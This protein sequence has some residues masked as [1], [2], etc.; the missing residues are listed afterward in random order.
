[1]APNDELAAIQAAL[2]LQPQSSRGEV[3]TE[4]ELAA[5]LGTAAAANVADFATAAQGTAA[6]AA[7]A[8]AAAP[9]LI[10][11]TI[12][13]ALVAGTNVTITPNDGADTIT[14]AAS[15]GGGGPVFSVMDFGAKG[16]GTDDAA[17]IQAA[18][19]ALPNGG[20]VFF[21]RGSYRVNSTLTIAADGVTL[22]GDPLGS[23]LAYYGAAGTACIT[24]DPAAV[25]R[26]GGIE[27]LFVSCITAGATALK[28]DNAYRWIMRRC[29]F[30]SQNGTT[31]IGI[32]IVG[33]LTKSCNLSE[34]H[35]CS[36]W[37]S[38]AALQMNDNVNGIRFIGGVLEG[39]GYAVNMPGTNSN[40][41]SNM[42]IGTAIQSEG[43]NTAGVII[44]MG[45]PSGTPQ[46]A[47]NSFIGCRIETAAATTIQNNAQAWY[48]QI[49]GGSVAVT[50][51]IVDSVT[52]AGAQLMTFYAANVDYM[53]PKNVR[54]KAMVV[55]NHGGTAAV[56]LG[57]GGLLASG[58]NASQ[59]LYLRS[60]GSSSV[61]V[62]E[63]ANDPTGGLTVFSGGATSVPRAVLGAGRGATLYPPAGG[64]ALWVI[65]NGGP[66]N[67]IV[68]ID[69]NG[70][71]KWGDV[72]TNVVDVSVGRSAAGVLAI[73]GP[74]VFQTTAPAA[75]AGAALPATPAGYLKVNINGTDRFM[76]YY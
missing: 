19:N 38:L 31:G 59:N 63:F 35:S 5:A 43:T 16:D 72:T 71:I 6:D 37:G 64:E 73:G 50:T 18:I 1:M 62:N 48:N 30:E 8:A 25:R 36:A 45:Q 9:E 10:R 34:F 42:F 22:K 65:K 21:P 29:R 75:G 66:A 49:I 28:L 15:G 20:T 33:S 52:T 47:Y 60:K 55:T 26:N 44:T 39:P 32:D 41:G 51:T 53:L 27:E 61:T 57:N 17:A 67:P 23:T 54:T 40:M 76:P 2:R 13:T 56:T 12:A 24:T 11:D 58:S 74:A 69:E 68:R 3:V 14:I 4:A 7:L 70:A 46:C